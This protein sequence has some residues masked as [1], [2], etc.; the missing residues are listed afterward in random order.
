MTTTFHPVLSIAAALTVG[1]SLAASVP[2]NAAEGPDLSAIPAGTYGVEKTH[3][4]I[5]FSYDHQGYSKPFLRFR[6]F[7][8]ALELDPSDL[9]NSSVSVTIDTNSIDSGVDIFD[10]HLRGDGFFDVEQFPTATFSS[11]SFAPSATGGTM[12]GDLTM[13]GITKPVTLDVTFNKAG[14]NF[15]SKV[16]QVGFSARG[17]IMRSDWDLGKY[18]PVVGDAVS[19]IIETE[20]QMAKK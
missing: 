3:A 4:Y 15:R 18:T 19:L 8:G 12:T 2:A 9:A 17:K 20:F 13:K 11:T 5:T 6:S 1:A 10:E 7:D 14:E 16:P